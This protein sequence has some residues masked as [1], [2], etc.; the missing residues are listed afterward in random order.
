M[1]SSHSYLAK[2]KTEKDQIM[3]SEYTR[4]K[5]RADNDPNTSMELLFQKEIKEMEKVE[6]AA[7]EV[8]DEPRSLRARLFEKLN[9]IVSGRYFFLCRS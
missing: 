2:K 7:F 9:N 1:D 6:L 5:S 4:R 8:T 3:K